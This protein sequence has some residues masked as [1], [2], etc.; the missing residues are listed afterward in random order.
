L[1]GDFGRRCR[2]KLHCTS[3]SPS[4][5]L[6]ACPPE[7]DDCGSNP[8]P[9]FVHQ[10]AGLVQASGQTANDRLAIAQ[11]SGEVRHNKLTTL[12]RNS[13][14]ARSSLVGEQASARSPSHSVI[15]R[16]ES[17]C[18]QPADS[19]GPHLSDGGQLSHWRGDPSRPEFC[20]SPGVFLLM[21]EV[22]YL[23]DLY[24]S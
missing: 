2:Q 13:T 24:L 20:P 22:Q 18:R 23:Q 1:V 17:Q 15:K 6:V 8:S 7:R 11:K 10:R 5:P 9:R 4:I 19:H 16:K 14:E 21:G 3:H 12:A